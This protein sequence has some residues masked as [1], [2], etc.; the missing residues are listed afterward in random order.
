[1]IYLHPIVQIVLMVLT[2]LFL[3][4]SITLLRRTAKINTET[5]R[6]MKESNRELMENLTQERIKLHNERRLL[7]ELIDKHNRGQR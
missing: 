6:L 1:M 5:H 4:L 2:T 7:Q 3:I